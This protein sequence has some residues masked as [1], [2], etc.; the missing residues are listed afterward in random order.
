MNNFIKFIY[1]YF[2]FIDKSNTFAHEKV[3][4]QIRSHFSYFPE[5]NN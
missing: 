5:I 3:G 4:E 2:V 1:E